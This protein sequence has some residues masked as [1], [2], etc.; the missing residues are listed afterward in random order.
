MDKSS[1]NGEVEPNTDDDLERALTDK[2]ARKAA[3][4]RARHVANPER[5]SARGLVTER[6]I[7]LLQSEAGPQFDP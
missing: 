5:S 7:E 1:T 3:Y 4:D 2:R 6:A